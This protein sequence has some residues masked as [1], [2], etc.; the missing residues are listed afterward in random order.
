[1]AEVLSA[2]G[3]KTQLQVVPQKRDQST[4]DIFGQGYVIVLNNKNIRTAPLLPGKIDKKRG[5]GVIGPL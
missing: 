2:R 5:L 4:K 1:M 3:E